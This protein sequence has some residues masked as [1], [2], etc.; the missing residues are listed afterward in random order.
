MLLEE[1][2]KQRELLRT[3]KDKNRIL[4]GKEQQIQ[5][6]LGTKH[7]EPPPVKTVKGGGGRSKLSLPTVDEVEEEGH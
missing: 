1:Q 2:A 3:L 5:E 4:E 6:L 7:S